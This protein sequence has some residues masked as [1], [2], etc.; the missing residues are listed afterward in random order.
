MQARLRELTSKVLPLT[1]AGGAAVTGLALLRRASLRQAVADGIA[2]AVAAV[3]K[4]CR[5]WHRSPSWRRTSVVAP[6]GAGPRAA[7][8]RSAGPRRNRLFRQD[9]HADREPP[10]CGV[11]RAGHHRPDPGIPDLADP[12]AAEVLLAAARACP[13]PEDQHGHAHATDEAIISAAGSLGGQ[14][15][16]EWTVIAEVPF[17]SSRGFSATIGALRDEA[18]APMLVLKGAPEQ[19]LPRCR[20]AEP[21]PSASMPSR[22]CTASPN[23]ACGCWRWRGAAGTATPPR[24]PTPTPTLSKPPPKIWNC[25]AMSAWQTPLDRRRGR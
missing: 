25:S 1:L 22:W 13:E 9:R 21:E 8:H 2:I 11:C 7:H 3:P 16:S 23:A 14:A 19:I 24:S 10:A 15:D 17:E 6:R 4:G 12:Q 20:F 5:W 18:Q